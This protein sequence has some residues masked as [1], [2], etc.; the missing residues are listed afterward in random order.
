MARNG[1][2][3]RGLAGADGSD[4]Q[5]RHGLDWIG[6]DWTGE[7]TQARN[8]WERTGADWTGR[9]GGAW[10]GN[11]RMGLAGM[12]WLGQARNLYPKQVGGKYVSLARSIADV[13]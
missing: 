5:R 6:T 2:D 9:R 13:G 3:R 11:D 7:A 12:D 10:T 8:G 4:R 1:V